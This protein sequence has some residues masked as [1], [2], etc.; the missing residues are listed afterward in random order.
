MEVFNFIIDSLNHLS[1]ITLFISITL[2]TAGKSTIGISSFLPPASLMLLLIFS[3][4]LPT[5]SPIFLWLAAGCGALLGSIM[6]YELGRFIY[7]FPR[8]EKRVSRYQS[9]INR[10][11]QLLKSKT[12]YIVFISRFL[13]ILRYLTPF[14]AGLLKL[15]AYGI[16]ITS[17]ISALV[18]SAL[19]ILIATGVLNITL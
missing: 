5:Y 11:Q 1:P 9:K 10:L 16:Y 8:L 14:S 7:R 18:W 12:Y 19:F 4:C 13:A 2:L 15:P 17:A 3:L 6:S